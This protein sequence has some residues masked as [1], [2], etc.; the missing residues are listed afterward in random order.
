MNM[1]IITW[2]P[3]IIALIAGLVQ[4]ILHGEKYKTNPIFVLLT[5]ILGTVLGLVFGFLDAFLSDTLF[6]L[7]Q[8]VLI[9]YL[10]EAFIGSVIIPI[11]VWLSTI[12]L[13]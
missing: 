9:S 5:I 1:D 8:T 4:L 2:I 7:D 3:F 12:K 10:F 11:V 6:I 13:E